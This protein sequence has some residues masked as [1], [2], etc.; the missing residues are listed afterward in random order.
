MQILAQIG[1]TVKKGQTLLVIDSPDLGSAISDLKKAE[2]DLQLK[3][4]ANERNKMLLEG[5]VIAKKELESTES[6]LKQAEAESQRAHWKVSNLG[7]R[8]NANAENYAVKAPI[9]GIVVDRQI[10]PGAEVRPDLAAPLFIISNA[11]FLWAT[12]DLPERDLGKVTVGQSIM[13]QVDAYPDETF[14]GKIQSIGGMIDP[15][16]RRIQVRCSVDNTKGRL[17]PEMYARITPIANAGRQVIRLPNTALITEGLYSY[18]FV[19]TSP[20]HLQKRRVALTTQSREF[21]IVHDGLNLKERVV[22]SGA[23]LLN[24]ELAAGK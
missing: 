1:D 7:G 5:G 12:I 15:A 23:I 24:S 13:I 20:G 11:D 18:V 2:A 22:V 9:A 14:S 3:R 19:E 16:T 6:D 21:S 8:G 17:K 10:N 4:Q